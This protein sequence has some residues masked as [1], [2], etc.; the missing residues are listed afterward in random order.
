M[1]KVRVYELARDL[2]MDSKELVEKLKAGGMNIKNYM[3]TLDEEATTKARD[4]V[5]GRVSEVIE[6]KRIKPRVIRRRKKTVKIEPEKPAVEPIVEPKEVE[7]EVEKRAPLDM[8]KA[9]EPTPQKVEEEIKKKEETAKAPRVP[10]KRTQVPSEELKKEAPTEPTPSKPKPKKKARKAR[11]KVAE[12]PAKIIKRP[13]EGPLRELIAKDE[14]RAL[15]AEPPVSQRLETEELPSI[16]AEEKKGKPERKK[17]DKK[18]D[19]KTEVAPKG[20]VRLRKIEVFERAD[21]YEG[22]MLGKKERRG[23]KKPKDATKKLKQT[24]I[25]VPKPIKRRIKVPEQVT[26]GELA[27]A[28][29]IKATEVIKILMSLGAPANINQSIDFETASLVADEFSYELELDLFDVEG[30]ISE[31]EDKPEDLKPR[32]PV[33][34]IMG[35]VDHG[36]T[37]LLD[38]IRQ[39]NIIGGES[40]GITQHIGAYYVKIEGGDIV[41]LDTPGHEAFTAMRARGAKVTDIIVLVVAADDGVMPQTVEAVNHARAANIPIIVAVNKID[42]AE[43]NI[44]KVTRELAELELVPEAWGGETIF[45]HIS[46]KTGEGVEELLELILLQAEVLELKENPDKPARGTII[47]A[48]LDKSRGPIATV[49]IKS[50]MLNQGDYFICGEHYGRLRAMLNHRGQRLKSAGPS[51]PVEIYGISGVPM[52]GDEFIVVED[53]KT[54]KQ[55]IEA[56]Q[57]RVRTAGPSRR[58]IVSLDDLFDRI[59]EGEIKELNLILKADVQG[60]IEALTDSLFKL[61]TE[62]VKVKI[63]HSSTGAIT[64]TDVMLASASGAII[65]GFSVRANPR[66]R[67]VAAKE[68]VDIRYYDVIYNVIKDI[69]MAM[70]GLLEPIYRENIIGQAEIKQ[71]FHVPKVGT[72][73]GCY[74]TDGHVE[75][76]ANV[77]LLRDDVVVFDGKIASLRR[78][79]DDVKEV[80]SGYECGIGL[81]NF[82]DV[83]PGD[84]FEVYNLEEEKAE[85]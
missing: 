36:K 54:A 4:I 26:V 1:A 21:L 42:K 65:I 32:P 7:V 41:F 77:R 85:L 37:S 9:S 81:E 33:V 76:N 58:G 11:K 53:E 64:E 12:E 67:D 71:I 17:K 57:A 84:V 35:H 48:K 40:G 6:E 20:S 30:V 25:T 82:Q 69:R 23:A 80:Q 28:M 72:V 59:K 13:E 50:G 55:V 61:S 56:R 31:V 24:E 52:A 78:F 3:S 22:R 63:I 16:P 74:V 79:K 45:G 60:S 10:K 8:K 68:E 5:A 18:R 2:S 34:T 73:A 70:A 19:K 15:R 51:I 66:V 47:E 49:L 44:D 75:R 39:S 43:A 14:K 38:Y 27:K 29:G 83:K 46:A 62:E